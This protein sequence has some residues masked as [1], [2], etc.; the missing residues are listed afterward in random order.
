MKKIILASGSPRRRELMKLLGVPFEVVISDFDES[1]IKIK[2]PGKFVERLS[3]EKAKAVAVRYKEAIVIGADTAVV[4]GK[5]ILGKPL[6][7]LD[8]GKMLSS[9]SG[10]EHL[11]IT[12]LTVIDGTNRKTETKSITSKVKMK[13]LSRDEIMA[14]IATGEPM[15]RAGAYAVNERGGLFVEKIDGDFFSIVGLPMKDLRKILLKLG[16]KTLI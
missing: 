7:E 15:D 14:Y 2:D 8:A 4:L 3:F 16:V 5:Q 10:M 1:S 12:G 6:D 11:I 13:K 9:L